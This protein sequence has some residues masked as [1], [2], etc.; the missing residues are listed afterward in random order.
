MFENLITKAASQLQSVTER[1]DA[2]AEALT[3]K[4]AKMQEQA[5]QLSRLRQLISSLSISDAALTSTMQET[6]VLHSDLALDRHGPTRQR[7]VTLVNEIAA[8]ASTLAA[9]RCL[10]AWV[11]HMNRS[12]QL[13]ANL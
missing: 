9:S 4:R 13:A 3:H 8:L 11:L 12:K 6:P 1:C 7:L 5:A 2:L 10:R